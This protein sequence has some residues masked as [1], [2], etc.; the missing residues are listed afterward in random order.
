MLDIVDM[1]DIVEMVDNLSMVDNVNMVDS[2]DM[3]NM[4]QTLGCLKMLL[5]LATLGYGGH[6]DKVHILIVLI[7]LN[8]LKLASAHLD[9]A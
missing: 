6:Q 9:C 3:V 8:R 7:A 2:L 5:L 1:V 4:Q